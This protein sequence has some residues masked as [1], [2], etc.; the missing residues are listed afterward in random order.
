M[1]PLNQLP[2]EI[3][4]EIRHRKWL[5]F[6]VFAVVSAVV[7]A[8]GFVWPYK[9]Q[10][11]VVIFVDDQN[12]IQP[13]MEGR[14]V[15]TKINEKA[16]A[17]RELLWTR[18]VVEK[19]ATDTDVFGEKADDLSSTALDNRVAEIR[20]N[21]FVK[22]RGNN[23]FDIGYSA[24]SPT[25]AFRAAQ[26]LS[27]S[28]I[29]ENKGR[30]K[31]ESRSAYD[32]ID[33]QVKSYERQLAQVEEDMSQFL[34]EN[35]EGTEADANKRLANLQNRL[36]L[37]KLEKE[38]LETRASALQR[39][40]NN[41]DPSLKQ[42]QT[43]DPYQQRISAMEEQLDALRLRYHDTYPDIVILREQID[44]LRKQRERAMA[45]QEESPASLGG[46]TIANP[47]Y[48]DIRSALVQANTDI[49][50]VE[51][52]IRA[53]ERLISEQKTRMERIQENKAQYSD[54][55]RDMK[56]NKEIYDDLLKR[57]ETARVSM[58]LNVEEQGVN[59]RI[60]ENAQYPTQPTGPQ[61][62]MFAIAGLFIG[63]IAPFG[64][65]A[66][67]LQVDPRIRSREQLEEALELP[68][69]EHLPEVR[70]PFEKRRDRRV[71]LAVVTMAILVTGAYIA[72]ALAAVFGVF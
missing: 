44:E 42:G 16:S 41:I 4:R 29:E 68:M 60:N 48:Q 65:V 31:E 5:A 15:T 34:S 20:R 28:F 3:A 40:M 24:S 35:V 59:Y 61:F 27:Q 50:T 36:E 12:I 30:R 1:L 14:A 69:L 37:A 2:S 54:L 6:F 33:R 47:I 45:N 63:L 11:Q 21:M 8:A 56:V 64:T 7:L 70:T 51:T 43:T 52:R 23:Y 9:Y 39:Q 26:K 55:T 67:L 57:R 72:V 66:A 19:I 53:F 38:Q 25:R 49:E 62:S 17:A 58:Y 46:E 10:S 13:L 18:S 22:T 32:F 71:A